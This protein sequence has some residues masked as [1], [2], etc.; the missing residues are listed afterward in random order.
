MHMGRLLLCSS[1]EAKRSSFE[2]NVYV[3]YSRSH[4]GLGKDE[5]KDDAVA[6]PSFYESEVDVY[7]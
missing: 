1:R 3:I 7:T 5:P 6:L 4:D 2:L